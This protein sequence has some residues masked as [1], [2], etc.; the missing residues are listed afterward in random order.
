MPGKAFFK[1]SKEKQREIYE[2]CLDEFIEYG[3][4]SAST[5]R[6]VKRAG[7]SKGVLFKYFTSKEKLFLEL[8]ER[9]AEQVWRELKIDSEKL[10]D[11]FFEALGVLVAREI[12]FSRENPKSFSLFRMI[13]KQPEHPVHQKAIYLFKTASN[14]S[15][16]L[17]ATRL[18]CHFRPEISTDHA[19]QLLIM[20][21]NKITE[22]FIETAR[23]VDWDDPEVLYEQVFKEM[24]PYFTIIKYGIY[25]REHPDE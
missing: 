14:L 15:L 8:C 16:E 13:L 9:T 10:P 23:H 19:I 24:E 12:R 21:S 2:A 18:A 1:L 20:I 7:T 5:N 3:Y 22:Q 17:L 4:D 25:P 11:D 6:I